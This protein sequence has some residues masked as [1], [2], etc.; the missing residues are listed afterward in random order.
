M[1]LFISHSSRDRWIAQQLDRRLREIDGV[2]TFLDE[3]DLQGGDHITKAIRRQIK[4]TDHDSPGQA[5]AARRTAGR[6]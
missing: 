5:F 6:L 4:K 3:N 2:E 1:R